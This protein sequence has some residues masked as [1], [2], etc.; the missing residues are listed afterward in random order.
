VKLKE[1]D[2]AKLTDRYERACARLAR[3]ARGDTFFGGARALVI[4]KRLK[5]M[6]SEV[7]ASEIVGDV[8]SHSNL[9]CGEW[10]A[11]ECPECGSVRFGT[12][13]ALNCC[14]ERGEA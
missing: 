10:A 7:P 1:A 13:A 4:A 12:V 9:S 11:Y 2:P 5:G 3:I 6:R 14:H 8:Y